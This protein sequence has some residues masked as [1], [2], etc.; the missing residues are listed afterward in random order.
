MSVFAPATPDT[1]Q[2]LSKYLVKWLNKWFI[3]LVEGIGA[4]N[5]DRSSRGRNI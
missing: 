1:C 3:A 2:V 5:Q 4:G